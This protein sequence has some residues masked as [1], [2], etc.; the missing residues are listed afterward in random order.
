[1]Y[2][3]ALARGSGLLGN[4]DIHVFTSQIAWVF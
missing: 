2:D 4:V 3:F 1:M